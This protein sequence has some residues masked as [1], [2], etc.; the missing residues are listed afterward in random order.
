[1]P[2]PTLTPR[3]RDALRVLVV[4]LLL[5]GPIW[6]PALH[7]DDP[8]YQYE[9]TRV[10]VDGGGVAL[11]NES[12]APSTPSDRIACAGTT[13]RVCAFERH[14]SRNHTVLTGIY[15]SVPGEGTD[16]FAVGPERY[17]YVRIDD[18]IY[19]PT[20]LANRSR[21]YVVANGT[22]YEAGA[23]PDGV[24][25]SGTLYR[26][27]LSL[28]RVSPT[29]AL[30][31]VSRDAD[32]VPGPIGRAAETGGAASHRRLAVPRTPIR[33]DAG[34]YYR[35]YLADWRGPVVES[36]WIEPLLVI[37]A[38]I[39]GLSVLFRLRRRLEVTYTGP[40]RTDD[41]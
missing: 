29:D 19:E 9:R 12:T 27:E 36:D 10:V 2:S 34:T 7:L 31:D 21:T 41:P 32:A 23:A 40:G 22:V 4:A 15:S 6:L 1:M 39:A 18:T 28:R 37:G 8:T 13:S 17:D 25:T 3:R 26:N 35:V 20:T 14:L 30:A 38:A 11:A 16:T 33:T 24:S 5:A